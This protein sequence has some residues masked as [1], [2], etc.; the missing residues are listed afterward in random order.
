MAS[1][2]SF[3]FIRSPPWIFIQLKNRPTGPRHKGA[4]GEEAYFYSLSFLGYLGT[5]FF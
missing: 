2:V 4:P 3:R 5:Q 1:N